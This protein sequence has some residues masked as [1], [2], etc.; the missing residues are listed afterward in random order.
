MKAMP[1]LLAVLLAGTS[2]QVFQST[3]IDDVMRGDTK[4]HLVPGV[5]T[6]EDLRTK[7]GNPDKVE[8]TR[9]NPVWTYERTTRE[10]RTAYSGRRIGEERDAY[11]DLPGYTHYITK[12]S[13]LTLFFDEDGLL[14]KHQMF[15]PDGQ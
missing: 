4:K 2:C 14:V 12:T 13:V 15:S 6:R 9:G 7:L 1:L 3:D 8:T 5:T 10:R 11:R